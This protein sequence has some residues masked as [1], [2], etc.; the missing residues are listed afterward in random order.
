MLAGEDNAAELTGATGAR[1]ALTAPGYVLRDL[2]GWPG[3]WRAARGRVAGALVTVDDALLARLDAFE[4][5]P[6]VY[7]RAPVAL[8]CGTQAEAYFLHAAVAHAHPE[9]LRPGYW[10]LHARRRARC[11]R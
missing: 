10:P 6:T 9:V 1:F 4:E 8:A 11:R 3:L 2:G 5:V 7:V